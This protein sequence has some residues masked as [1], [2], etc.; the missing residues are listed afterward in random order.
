MKREPWPSLEVMTELGAVAVE[1]V[2]DDGEAQ[3]GAAAGAALLDAHP[4]ETLGQPGKVLRRDARA[5]ILDTEFDI[6][7]RVASRR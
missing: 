2:L 6:A 7:V 4:I 3:A 5:K 1:D